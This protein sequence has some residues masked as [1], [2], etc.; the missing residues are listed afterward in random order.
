[1]TIIPGTGTLSAT[2]IPKIET[3]PNL[4]EK[5]E[6]SMLVV[7]V[8]ELNKL[9]IEEEAPEPDVWY[10][11][12]KYWLLIGCSLS[13]I[14][15]ILSAIDIRFLYLLPLGPYAAYVSWHIRKKIKK[16]AQKLDALS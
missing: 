15:A 14:F 5:D 9:K 1:M 13:A 7:N 2:G 11:Q 8:S 3:T 12:L 16:Y 4:P 10:V 6:N